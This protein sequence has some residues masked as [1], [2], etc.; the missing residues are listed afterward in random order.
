MR[1]AGAAKVGREAERGGRRMT[2]R[3]QR[4][5]LAAASFSSRPPAWP[6]SFVTTT[7][8]LPRRMAARFSSSEKGPRPVM[9]RS[10]G[11]PAARQAASDSGVSRTR[12]SSGRPHPAR[13]LR[14]GGEVPGARREQDRATVGE[15]EDRSLGMI[16]GKADALFLGF[17]AGGTFLRHFAV[18][19]LCVRGQHLRP[20]EDKAGD[21]QPLGRRLNASR[22]PR[23][24]RGGRH[25]RS[26]GGPFSCR[27][28]SALPCRERPERREIPGWS[29]MA[30]GVSVAVETRTSYP[31]VARPVAK[32]AVSLV[33]PM[34]RII[35]R[36][37]GG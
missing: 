6:L 24:H 33:P 18:G 22:G 19:A 15:G 13:R 37:L 31:A 5:S 28:R 2:T 14:V 32:G 35:P 29:P 12:T 16:G 25:P 8:T 4:E 17:S 7:P 34:S 11:M 30:R 26:P 3:R 20:P 9:I 36:S 10:A 27:G 1:S 21:A 23:R